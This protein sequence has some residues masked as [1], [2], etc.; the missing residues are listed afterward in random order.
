LKYLKSHYGVLVAALLF[1]VLTW[2]FKT[3]MHSA[4]IDEINE[5]TITAKEIQ[6]ASSMQKIWGVPSIQISTRIEALKSKV[7][8]IK[9]S[10]FTKEPKSLNASLIGLSAFEVESIVNEISNMPVEIKTLEV[11]P[12]PSGYNMK[13]VLKW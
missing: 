10:S 9:I 7:P 12:A 2:V 5:N 13:L 8:N 4:M 3:Y 11:T 6:E 1:L